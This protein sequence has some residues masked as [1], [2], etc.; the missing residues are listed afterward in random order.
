MMLRN[1]L[2]A[3]VL[4]SSLII[5]ACDSEDDSS[6][7]PA[8]AEA[9]TTE[10]ESD[11]ATPIEPAATEA[12][13]TQDIEA[14]TAV[15][16]AAL[17]T[18]A[19]FPPGWSETP[20]DNED[21]NPEAERALAECA[22]VDGDKLVDTEAE[23][24]TGRFSDPDGETFIDQTVGLM[25][26]ED[27]AAAALPD[28][29]STDVLTCFSDVYNDLFADSLD[30]GDL[31]D[32]TEF[33][34]ISVAR[35]NVTPVGDETAALRVAVPVSVSGITVDV[36]VD[37]VVT[38]VGRSL[39]GLSFQSTFNPIDIGILDDYNALAASRLPG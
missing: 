28:V 19:D 6:D 25:A 32:D 26:S 22:G 29:T 31:P 23:A 37:L 3:A 36:T 21:D 5:A 12:A 16:Q 13:P 2:A 39:S 1:P 38:R 10:A 4:V 20:S 35:L 34:E 27:E 30:D 7:T 17:L 14:D 24:E 8:G 11:A 33:G 18:L 15:A 9:A